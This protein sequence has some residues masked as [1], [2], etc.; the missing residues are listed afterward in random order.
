MDMLSKLLA[1]LQRPLPQ[2]FLTRIAGWL[3]AQEIRWLKNLLIKLFDRAYDINW[4]EAV[5]Q[6]PDDYASFN[7]FFTRALKP[8]ARPLPEGD[9]LISPCDGALSE[10][11]A[12]N[13]G[14]LLQ[15]KDIEYPLHHL[16]G[17][18]NNESE[19]FDKYHFFTIYLAPKDYHRIH[20][21]Q[22]GT[23]TRCTHIP[24]R[25]FSVSPGTAR[26]IPELFCRNE[27]VVC[28]FED[29]QKRTFIV[30]LVGAMM[31]GSIETVWRGRFEHRRDQNAK[32]YALPVKP[33]VLERGEE[34]GR[35]L[36][37]STVIVIYPDAVM[38]D[39][40]FNTE[41]KNVKLNQHLN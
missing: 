35:F 18:S 20:M 36:M 21:P 34:M 31:V 8:D 15:A 39:D 10:S 7:D 5:H 1:Q 28:W 19:A 33:I 22:T 38:T 11:G 12:I 40:I 26:N 13:D 29:Q 27:R 4:N 37:G 24:G 6:S 17:C 2:H 14:Q 30:V 32:D 16:L 23:L 25:L 3:A 9:G 41:T